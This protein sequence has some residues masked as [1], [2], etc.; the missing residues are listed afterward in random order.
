MNSASAKAVVPF[1]GRNFMTCRIHSTA[2]A[3]LLA[4]AWHQAD[5]KPMTWSFSADALTMDPYAHNNTFTQAFLNN[6]YEGLTRHND[7]LE[8]EPALAESWT[9]VNPTTWRFKL[10][11]GV[12]FHNGNGFDAD[13]VVFS[14]Q[15]A[16]TPGALVIGNINQVKDVRKVDATTV[17]IETK[18]PFPLLLSALTG[19]YMMD[20]EW[21]QANDATVSSNLQ[22][23]K[24]NFANRNTNGTGPFVLKSREVDVQ[25]VFQ[26]N[27]SWWDRPK[28]NLT[29]V[30]FKPIKSDATRT[31]ALLSGAIDATVAIPLQDIQ[32]VSAD[33]KLQ[34][35]QGPELR[36]IYFGFDHFRD[37]LLYSSVKGK[38]PFKD[39]RVRE[40]FYRAIDI[41]AIK[42]GVM[43][44]NSWPTGMMASP[45]LSGA[46]ADLNDRLPYDQ[47][48]AKQLLAEAGYPDGFTVALSCPNDRYVYDEQICLAAI[49]MLARVGI[50]V[51]SQIEPLAKWA[52]RLNGMD[53]SFFMVGHAG[54]PAADVYALLSEVIATRGPGKGGLNAGRYSNPKIDA[55]I[56]QIATEADEPKRRTLIREALKLEKDDVAHIPLH[57]QP[58]VWA[59]KK[60]VNFLPSPD[61]RLKLWY[62]KVD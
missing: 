31:A 9:L 39:R 19:F 35:V 5:A 17:E 58:I 26:A 32:R 30:T 33:A 21:A 41:E 51:E 48:R 38:N 4:L 11:Q 37:E 23:K 42:R 6:I 1:S 34:V 28:H 14:W 52:Q 45:Y 15:R 29:E 16:N 3:A 44:N 55:L 56:D 8:I 59:S 22:E 61:N 2:L 46:P 54:L 36:T 60:G 27:A 47:A 12:K 49:S 53:L 50:K 24:E 40:A 10:R 18:L 62:V 57:Q 13:D 43:R 7:K 25:S 20:R